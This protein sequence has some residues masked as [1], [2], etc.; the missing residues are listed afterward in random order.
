MVE[1]RNVY[2]NQGTHYFEDTATLE[3][4]GSGREWR[5]PLQYFFGRYPTPLQKLYK[6]SSVISIY[7]FS[8]P[9]TFWDFGFQNL[10]S[11][12]QLDAKLSLFL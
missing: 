12:Q 4:G 6:I 11:K 1:N 2:F 10:G 5:F 7:N 3:V 8:I 9:T